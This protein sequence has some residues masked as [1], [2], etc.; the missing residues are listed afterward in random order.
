MSSA[1]EIQSIISVLK[2]GGHEP[3]ATLLAELEQAKERDKNIARLGADVKT[4]ERLNREADQA[5]GRAEARARHTEALA[6]YPDVA[7]RQRQLVAEYRELRR[8]LLAVAGQL[9]TA[10]SEGEMLQNRIE[11]GARTFGVPRPAGLP[12]LAPVLWRLEDMMIDI[13]MLIRSR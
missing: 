7:N 12:Q 13:E 4:L 6:L 5:A 11:K 1:K 3:P 10:T 2:T 9:N 8:R